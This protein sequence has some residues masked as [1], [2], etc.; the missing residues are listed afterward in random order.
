MARMSSTS[1]MNRLVERLSRLPGIGKRSAQRLAFH[2]IKQPADEVNALAAA[3]IE[4]KRNTKQC[5]ICHNLTESDPCPICG[6]EQRDSGVVLVVEQPSDVVSF[7]QLG[8]F[9]GVYHVLM[10]RLAPLDGIGA[11]DLTIDLLLERVRRGRVDAKPQAAETSHPTPHTPHPGIREVII[12][13]NATI[14]GDGTAMYLVQELNKLG[15]HVTRLARGLP[16]GSPMELVSKAVLADALQGRR[17]V[18][19]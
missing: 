2:L 13:T 9:K 14:E 16:F 3:L 6:D 7:E 8:L 1:A 17:G 11:G 18:D 4:M 10:G 15:V 19:G 5:S 12:G